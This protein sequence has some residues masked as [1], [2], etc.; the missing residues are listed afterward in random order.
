MHFSLAWLNLVH[1]PWRTLAVLTGMCLVLVLIFMQLG[2]HGTL[3][4]NAV[5]LYDQLRF[6]LVLVSPEYVN[7]DKAGAFPRHRLAQALAAPG[8]E[9]ALPLYVDLALWRNPDTRRRAR[10]RV[11]GFNL[12]DRPWLLSEVDGQLEGLG[13]L[14]TALMDRR[15]L[16]ECGS[17]ETGVLTEIRNHRI[18]VRGQ[19]SLGTCFGANGTLLVSDQNFAR[20]FNRSSLDAVQV[21]LVCLQAGAD[22]RKTARDLRAILPAD[23]RVL[24]RPEIERQEIR[25]WVERTPAGL[26]FGLG[27]C[28][29]SSVGAVLLYQVLASD[30]T[31]HRRQYA[32]LK[33]LGYHDRFLAWVVLLKA[34]TLAVL[35]YVPALAMTTVLYDVT[36]RA[37]SLP[38]SL[39]AGRASLVLL[40]ALLIGSAA[41]LVALRKIRT[42]NPADLF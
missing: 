14:D 12:R 7:L 9:R 30:V 28:V 6:Q 29:A 23:V 36:T 19:F 37:T 4:A 39:E 27:I 21:G 40:L 25:Y 2:F 13:E 15:S 32:T 35:A 5:L 31:K 17:P 16:P 20:L 3:R 18:R 41:G 38:L 34:G 33:A 24:T 42:A 8:V 10:M 1:T 11:L 22:P 26:M